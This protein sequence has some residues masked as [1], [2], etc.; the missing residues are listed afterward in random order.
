[1]IVEHEE[2]VAFAHCAQQL[3]ERGELAFDAQGM[4]AGL[5]R[6][7]G[8]A[9][10]E[11]AAI[12]ERVSVT[13]ADAGPSSDPMDQAIARLVEHTTERV[14]FADEADRPCPHCGFPREISEQV[15]PVYQSL[16]GARGGADQIF[17]DRRARREGLEAQQTAA[18]AAERQAAALEALAAGAGGAE[19]AALRAEIAE[20]RAELANGHDDAKGG[21][22]LES[23]GAKRGSSLEPEPPRPRRRSAA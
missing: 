23:G 3:D 15:R 9:Q 16:G 17:L 11:V 2:I 21:P 13:Y 5:E 6:C 18:S 1:V 10:Q 14:L 7:P 4:P 8:Y 12:L 20:L 19:V 22:A